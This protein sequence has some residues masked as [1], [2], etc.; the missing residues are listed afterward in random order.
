MKTQNRK[1]EGECVCV[2]W[3]GENLI[4]TICLQLDLL[5]SVIIK[6]KKVLLLRKC[7]HSEGVIIK[8]FT[9][10][11]VLAGQDFLGSLAYPAKT[12]KFNKN[13]FL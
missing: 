2:C 3:R 6:S 12:D 13:V 10:P 8:T 4:K 5:L 11:F 7:Y 1:E 9:S